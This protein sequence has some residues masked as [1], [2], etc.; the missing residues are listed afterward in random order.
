[1]VT[2]RYLM[3]SYH[4]IIWHNSSKNIKPLPNL[5]LTCAFLWHVHILKLNWMCITVRKNNERTLKIS[6]FF[7]LKEAL[8]WK[9]YQTMTNFELDLCIPLR[10]LY[11]YVIFELNV[12][13]CSGDNDRKLK[14]SWWRKNEMT[15]GGK[16]GITD[17]LTGQQ[18]C[19]YSFVLSIV[20]FSHT[21][22]NSHI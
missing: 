8:H 3:C 13:N 2:F 10:Y 5:N 20:L 18:Y 11:I 14:I 12:Y 15:N 17:V 21:K 9:N 4:K 22:E 19:W 7:S 6:Y 1:M 16:D